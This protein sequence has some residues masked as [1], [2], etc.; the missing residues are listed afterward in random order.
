MVVVVDFL[1]VS[2]VHAANLGEAESS[3]DRTMDSS[4]SGGGGLGRSSLSKK[5]PGTRMSTL[6]VSFRFVSISHPTKLCD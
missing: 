3:F 5:S 1:F 4:Y 2:F 6:T